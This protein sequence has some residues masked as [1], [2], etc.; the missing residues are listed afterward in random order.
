LAFCAK[1]A[2]GAAFGWAAAGVAAAVVGGLAGACAAAGVS[3]A[4][5]SA[6]AHPIRFIDTPG[7]MLKPKAQV[8]APGVGRSIGAAFRSLKRLSRQC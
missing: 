1:P 6:I 5:A 8:R 7:N 2:G 4:A 3:Q